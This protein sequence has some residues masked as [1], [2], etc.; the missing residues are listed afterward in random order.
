MTKPVRGVLTASE[1]RTLTES[2]AVRE[3]ILAGPKGGTHIALELDDAL[4]EMTKERDAETERANRVAWAVDD[5]L[6]DKTE[7][8]DNCIKERIALRILINQKDH[9]LNEYRKEI[10]EVK[11]TVAYSVKKSN[12]EWENI[13]R[14]LSERLKIITSALYLEIDECLTPNDPNCPHCIRVSKVIDTYGK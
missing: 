7:E 1:R 3:H 6:R 4:R 9:L 8:R 5:A 12:I 13:C 10:D 11:S 2:V 14:D